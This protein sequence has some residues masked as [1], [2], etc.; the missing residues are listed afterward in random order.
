MN[1][2]IISLIT[3]FFSVYSQAQ[4]WKVTEKRLIPYTVNSQ[5][6]D[7]SPIFSP[8]SMHLF[9]ARTFDPKNAGGEFD[10]DIWFSS[11]DE[12]GVFSIAEPLKSLNNKF[13]NVVVGFNK[14]GNRLYVLNA[15]D[16]KKD[17]QKGIS[18]SQKNGSSWSNPVK[19]EIPNLDI[20]GDF[21]GFYVS[22]DEETIIISY[23]GPNSLGE[24][25]LYV[26]NL[27]KNDTMIGWSEPIHLGGTIN[28]SGFE[29]SPFLSPSKDTLYFSSNG[30]GGAG[31]ADIF[32]SVRETE[33][34]LE[35][36]TP[37]ALMEPFNSPKFDAYFS[38]EGKFAYW[39]SNADSIRSDIFQVEILT[40]PLLAIS[41]T[42]K[43]V[44]VYGGTDGEINMEI[45]S[46]VPNYTIEW[47]TGKNNP[48]QNVPM[49]TYIC[50]VTDD[51]GRIA[52]CEVQVNQPDKPIEIVPVLPEI[53]AD[54]EIYFDLNSSYLNA[55]NRKTLNEFIEKFNQLE[56]VKLVIESHCDARASNTYNI[57]LSEKRFNRTKNYLAKKGIKA[58]L[59][60]GE[61]KG[62]EE[63]RFNC[64]VDCSEE[65]HRENR[66]TTLVTKKQ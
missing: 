12:N 38:Y 58:E 15:Y 65:Q 46:G 42:A 26:S 55:E 51:L 61:Y 41:C 45:T 19:V 4:F 9:F 3:L 2:I 64:G 37:V 40:P 35:W 36:S 24:E 18:Y 5:Y 29:M 20:E 50:K 49:G 33:S 63:L 31:D 23:N 47:S 6:E 13:N 43:D 11:K 59:I 30:F 56:N 54:T 16:G 48:I 62:E 21:Y 27:M 17:T 66:R 1:K 8:D 22:P 7:Q 32:Y 10:Q 25:D 44:T 39:S 34:W 52:E 60:S 28:S 14:T 57:W 53:L